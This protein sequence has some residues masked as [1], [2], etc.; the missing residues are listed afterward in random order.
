MV[1]ISASTKLWA[2]SMAEQFENHGMLDELIT[3]YAYS[4]NTFARRF[5]R[6]TDKEKIPGNKII[7]NILLAVLIG[8]FRQ[9]P[10]IWNEL[11]DVWAAKKLK[12]GLSLVYIGW[13]GMSLHTI[14][15]AKKLGMI[16]IVERGSSHIL[17]QDEILKEEYSRYSK[18]FSIHPAVIKKEL[19]EYEAAD[20]ISVPSTFVRN[21]FVEQGVPETKLFVN[22]FGANQS[23]VRKT[24]PDQRKEKKFTIVYMGTLSI[25]KGLIYFFKSLELLGV[26]EQDYVVLFLGSIDNE[27]KPTIEKYRKANWQFL[28]HVN[29]YRLP[30]YL[31]H[32][33]I[34]VQPSVE[35]GLSMVIPQMMACGVPV[36]ITPN[37][38]GEN[39][40]RHNRNGFVVPIR[41]P[42]A[43]ADKLQWA[44]NHP[45]DLQEMKK[46]VAESIV[47][48]FT[49]E[50]YGK[51]YS[52]FLELIT[53][54]KVVIPS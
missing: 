43:I 31:V 19:S 34:G 8:K 54:K 12:P 33:D 44:Y 50:A 48:D 51:R 23:F 24:R 26:P 1:S 21:S 52:E 25:R 41:D 10:H 18:K 40:I 5:V 37:T 22:P 17:V 28:G 29:H 9:F 45:D 14:H 11:F 42:Q 53:G 6:R 30:D 15:R 20:Y 4:K 27:I 47:K 36:I 13:S 3:T 46:N 38:G 35:E 16:S 7:T 32:C 49:W 39:I 2:F